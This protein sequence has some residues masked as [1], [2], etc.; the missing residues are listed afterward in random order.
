MVVT[1][2]AKGIMA[3]CALA[4]GRKTGAEL[5]LIGSSQRQAG[6]EIAST[7]ADFTSA[8]LSAHYYRCNVTD[9]AAVAGVVAQIEVEV[10]PITGFVHGAGANV[11]RRFERVDSAAAF[12]EVAPKVLGAATSS[13]R[14]LIVT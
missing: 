9:A 7:L 10:G 2:G 6:D 11:P 13:K 12:K 8:G 1:G 14:S 3:Q 4:L 5:V